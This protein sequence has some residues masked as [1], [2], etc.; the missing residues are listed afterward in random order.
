ME[1]SAK[2]SEDFLYYKESANL[3]AQK[4]SVEIISTGK[5]LIFGYP[6]GDH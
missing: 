3:Y 5:I 2:K 1:V 4:V 6:N